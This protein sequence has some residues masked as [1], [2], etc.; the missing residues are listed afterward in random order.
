MEL[1]LTEFNVAEV[2]GSVS[3]MM[4][5]AAAAQLDILRVDVAADTG[6]IVSDRTKVR[7]VLVN[8]VGNACK[9]TRGGRVTLTASR[10]LRHGTPWVVFRVGDTG[11]GMSADQLAHIFR[12]F[13]QGDPSTTRRYGGTGLGLAIT[14]RLCLLMGGDVEAASEPGH[15]SVFS[16][17]LPA[18]TGPVAG[19]SS[20]P[21][22]APVGAAAAGGTV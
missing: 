8:L 1:D 18:T 14:R 19:A 4:E 22:R 5:A 20:A 6:H 3:T 7:Q 12:E 2:V 10:E 9:F 17:W 13:V 11:I 15:G 16:V 21:P